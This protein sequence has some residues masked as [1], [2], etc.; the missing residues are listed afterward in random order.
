MKYRFKSLMLAAVTLAALSAQPAFAA[1]QDCAA[2]GVLSTIHSRFDYAAAHYLKRDLAI[3]GLQ[4]IRESHFEGRDEMHPVE[5]VYCHAKAAMSDG[6]K[7][8][9]WYLIERSWGFVGLG[10]S[11]TL[12]VSGL[13]PWHLYGRDCRSLR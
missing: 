1:S 10:Q 11:V 9:L 7:R 6:R 3:S 2:S 12:C 4:E 8:D 13:D 5:R